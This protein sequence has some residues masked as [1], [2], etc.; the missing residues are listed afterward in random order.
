MKLIKNYNKIIIAITLL[1]ITYLWTVFLKIDYNPN[2]VMKGHHDYSF[3]GYLLFFFYCIGWIIF[4]TGIIQ[5][6]YHLMGTNRLP[7]ITIIY[8]GIIGYVFFLL[9]ICCDFDSSIVETGAFRKSMNIFLPSVIV[10][11]FSWTKYVKNIHM[12]YKKY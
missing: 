11:S 5:L 6:K 2:H 1:I 3:R 8:F 4:L 10:L 12:K 9:T 7:L